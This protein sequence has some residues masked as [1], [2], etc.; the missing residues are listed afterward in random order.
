MFL[1]TKDNTYIMLYQLCD[2][3]NSNSYGVV[4]YHDHLDILNWSYDNLTRILIC[5][6]YHTATK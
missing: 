1:V 4:I 5:Y 2:E 3:W 6:N